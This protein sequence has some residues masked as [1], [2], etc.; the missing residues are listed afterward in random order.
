MIRAATVL[1]AA[2]AAIPASA[3]QL[4]A[5]YDIL[6]GSLLVGKAGVTGEVG[7]GGYALSLNASM[8]GLVGAVAGG[9]GSASASGSFAGG[10]AVSKGYSLSASNGSQSRTIRIGMAGGK[11][12]RTIVN[13]PFITSPERAPVTEAH[14]RNV[15]DPLGA[16]MMPVKGGDP[17]D[18]ENCNRTLPIYDGAQRFDVKLRHAGSEMVKIKGYSGPALVC[19]ARYVPLGG[20]FPK[21]PQTKF[22]V[23][24]RQ[25]SVALAPVSGGVVLA[26]VKITV[27]TAV[28]TTTI[29]AR[30][31]PGAMDAVPTASIKN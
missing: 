30:S 23:D 15:I 21:R 26:P 12:T 2:M 27:T 19:S 11:V 29:I 18:P 4:S 16:L 8:T 9:K 31:F 20:H 17:F 10:R 3:E 25:M 13:P 28:G 14:K 5:R 1:I 6:V 7:K 22:M 24:N